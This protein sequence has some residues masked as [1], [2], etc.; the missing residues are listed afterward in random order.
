MLIAIAKAYLDAD[1]FHTEFAKELLRKAIKKD[2]DNPEPYVLIGI[3]C[4]KQGDGSAAYESF[5]KALE[6]QPEYARA[7]YRLGKIFT[8][9]NNPVYLDYF[10]SALKSD[11]LYA[12]ALYELYY[13]YYYRETEKAM[14]Y[15]NKYIA[16]SDYSPENDYR[17]TDILF[18]N[19][20]F[21]EALDKGLKLLENNSDTGNARLFKLIANC[22][23]ELHQPDRAKRYMSTYFSLNTDTGFLEKDYETMADICKAMDKQQDS[24]ARYYILASSHAKKEADKF[25]LI[26]KAIEMYGKAKDFVKQS[27]CIGEYYRINPAATNVDLFNWGI[28]CYNAQNYRGADSVFGIYTSKYPDQRYGYYWRARSNVAL[29]TTMEKGLAIP[30]Y[31]KLIDIAGKDTTDE[32]NVTRLIEAYSYLASYKANKENDYQSSRDYFEKVLQ[33]QPGN[34][35]AQKYITILDKFIAREKENAAKQKS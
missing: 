20:K 13:H 14:G 30:Y 31:M 32:H 7:N 3:A 18:V 26:K 4:L 12:P 17:M 1:T 29:D 25:S 15:L 2:K 6:I 33:L 5:R 16:A 28:A 9:Q 19:K 35:E 27:L 8:A 34:D 22:Y 21:P 23:K 24:A 10:N 11:S